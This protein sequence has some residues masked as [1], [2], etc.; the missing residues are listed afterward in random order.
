MR[1][2][3]TIIQA[4]PLWC[5]LI[6]AC[7]SSYSLQAKD[8]QPPTGIPPEKVADYV[9]AVLDA[10]RTIYTNQVVNRMQAKSIVSAAEHWEQKMP[11]R[12]PPSSSNI[13]E[14]LSLNQGEVFD[15]ASSAS[16][17]YTSAMPLPPTWNAGH[18]RVL[19]R[20][21]TVPLWDRL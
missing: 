19:R 15:T 6:L 12:F 18:W 5:A 21:Q 2:I 20:R 7:A 3:L 13:G 10:D 14:S 11:C 4:R 17:R 1:S 9:H 8:V 16:G